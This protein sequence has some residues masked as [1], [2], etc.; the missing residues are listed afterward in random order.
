MKTFVRL[1][2]ILTIL[3]LIDLTATLYWLANDIAHEANPLM[4]FFLELSPLSFI[5]AKLGMSG[6]G[7]A[8]LCFLRK[9]FK[10]IIFK[11]LLV[12]NLVYL[13]VFVYHLWALLFL[14]MTTN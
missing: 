11:L 1:A 7:I 3:I 13:A 12:L 6:V 8:I 14:T 10:K 2:Y 9:R 4:N 5:L